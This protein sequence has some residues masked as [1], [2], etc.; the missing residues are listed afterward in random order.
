MGE[1]L[2]KIP[3]H[4]HDHIRRITE[5]A[6]L[7][8]TP[9]S[10]ERIAAAWLEKSEIFDAKL[11][12]YRMQPVAEFPPDDGRGALALT[13]SGSIVAIGPLHGGSGERN[14]RFAAYS[15]IG[16]R[17]DVPSSATHDATE[18]AGPIK[19]DEQLEF[20]KGPVQRT[21]PIYRIAVSINQLSAP[22]E[23]QRLLEATQVIAEEFAEV[24]KTIVSD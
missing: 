17:N 14:T 12:E 7:P 16:L 20:R 6:G 23:N 2:G 15:S 8:D 21:S 10:V 22:E 24:N 4:I 5:Q 19:T 9:E 13:Y 11:D 3:E 18:L 1:N